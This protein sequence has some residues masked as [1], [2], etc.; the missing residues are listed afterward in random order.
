MT[1]DRKRLFEQLDPPPG[2]IERFRARLAE[3]ESSSKGALGRL[4]SSISARSTQVARNAGFL[5]LAGAAAVLALVVAVV[6][7]LPLGSTPPEQAALDAETGPS[8]AGATAQE[9]PLDT[10][11]AAP[12]GAASRS[13]A[14]ID[15]PELDWLLGRSSSLAEV[16]VTVG[17]EE[18]E[19]VQVESSDP[20]I[21]V[22]IVA[23]AA[24]D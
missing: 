1:V 22:F 4:R 23:S 3:H 13:G 14:I 8:S 2:G 7:R 11:P 18:A 9:S 21:R 19:V 24:E 17:G 10:D 20:R 5:R 16:S 6:M 12:D 15:A